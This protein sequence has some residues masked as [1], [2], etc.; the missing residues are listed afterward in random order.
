M[1][2]PIAATRSAGCDAELGAQRAHRRTGRRA[3]VPRQPACTAATAP[4]SRSA[5]SSGTQSAAR[6]AI[7]DVGR[8]RHER[9][10]LGPLAA[11]APA[12]RADDHV[13]APVHLVH[14]DDRGAPSDAASAA[15]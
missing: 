2:G 8:V 13:R 11:G 4:V 15:A 14:L 10:G 7:A 3:H 12:R 5:I 9:V 1:L 6:T